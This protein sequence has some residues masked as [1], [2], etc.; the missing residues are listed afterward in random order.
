MRPTGTPRPWQARGA[1]TVNAVRP[2]PAMITKSAATLTVAAAL[3]AL[4]SPAAHATAHTVSSGDELRSV[5]ATDTT[6][7]TLGYTYTEPRSRT[8][9]GITAGH[10]NKNHSSYVEDHTTGAIGHFVLTAGDPDDPLLD[11]YGLIDFGTNT[12]VQTMYGMPVVGMAAINGHTTICHDGI[13]TGTD[14]GQL[15]DC[16][17]GPQYL[18][19]GMAAGIPGD[20]GGPVW[21]ISHNG[22]VVVGI[23]LGDHTDSDGIRHGRFIDLVD[24]A[25]EIDTPYNTV[26]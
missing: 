14:C 10:C 5:G 8:A 2:R 15:G 22:A 1:T 11:D 24:V 16:F 7:C 18:T 6:V 25:N 4:G 12:P 9:Y 17:I 20:S 21:Q 13:R 3:S 26:I 23:W 19:N